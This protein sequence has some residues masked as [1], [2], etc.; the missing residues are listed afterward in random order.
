M[1]PRDVTVSFD[2]DIEVKTLADGKFAVNIVHTYTASRIVT[3]QDIEESLTLE[4]LDEAK[5]QGDNKITENIFSK[6]LRRFEDL[7]DI[8][9]R[10]AAQNDNCGT[11]IR[12]KIVRGRWE[13]EADPRLTNRLYDFK[14]WLTKLTYGN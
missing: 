10:L 1:L 12:R 9:Y 13:T 11:V 7:Y 2:K 5:E 3:P 8:L 4:W 6:V 14:R